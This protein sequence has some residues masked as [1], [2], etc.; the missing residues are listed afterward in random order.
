MELTIN[1]LNC[2]HSTLSEV[3]DEYSQS[4]GHIVDKAQGTS[5]LKKNSS[6]IKHINR[7]L[8]V[9]GC[10][11]STIHDI[12]FEGF[13]DKLS[14]QIGTYFAT[15]ATSYMKDVKD[16][17]KPISLQTAISYMSSYKHFFLN[18]FR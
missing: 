6:A 7:A 9:I 10:P 2:D 12:P 11:Y 5:L 3:T 17:G 16:G 18:K 1:N 15:E 4:Y 14:G 13:T 8:K